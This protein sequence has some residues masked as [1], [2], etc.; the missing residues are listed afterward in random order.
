MNSCREELWKQ[1]ERALTNLLDSMSTEIDEKNLAIL[2]EFIDNREYGVALEWLHSIVQERSLDLS[3][4]NKDEMLR[5]AR[6]MN[7]S[8]D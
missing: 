1:A 6:S 3:P 4:Q 5:L 7:I 8:L 2:K